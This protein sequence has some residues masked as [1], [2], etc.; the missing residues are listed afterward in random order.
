M[1]GC[2]LAAYA[3]SGQRSHFLDGLLRSPFGVRTVQATLAH[4][5][6]R[7]A[8]I[9]LVPIFSEATRRYFHDDLGQIHIVL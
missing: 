9:D 6:R 2:I 7:M 1:A 5:G 4:F 3:D 8:Q